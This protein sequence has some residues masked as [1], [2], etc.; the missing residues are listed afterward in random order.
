VTDDDQDI[1]HR[2]RSQLGALAAPAP[3][4][5]IPLWVPPGIAES[6]RRGDFWPESRVLARLVT[7]PRMQTVWAHLTRRR[8]LTG[9]Y[10]HPTRVALNGM[11]EAE[12]QQEFAMLML[13]GLVL[14]LAEHRPRTTTRRELDAKQSER[15]A[16]AH[17]LWREADTL[18][19]LEELGESIPGHAK[20]L[21]EAAGVLWQMG[22]E[23][24]VGE[25][26]VER[27]RGERDAQAVAM[28][29]AGACCWLFGK[30]L[31]KITAT[32]ASVALD[33]LVTPRNVRK[34]GP[35]LSSAHKGS[36]FGPLSAVFKP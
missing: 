3:S 25:I 4:I 19:Y 36:F 34:W 14:E 23:L 30:P 27:D 12:R 10:L 6:V 13:F 20:I 26:V 2:Q 17:K 35:I 8:R 11:A 18:A 15:K 7:D 28:T 5:K 22:G 31:H 33:H 24:P 1:L 29:I 9:Q 32:L 16:M 21:S